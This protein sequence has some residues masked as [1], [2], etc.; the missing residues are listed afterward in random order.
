MRTG[1]LLLI[2]V[3]FFSS[4]EAADLGKV[5]RGASHHR[6]P[7]A[8]QLLDEKTAVIANRRSGTLT[9]VDVPGLSV[10]AEFDFQGEPTD[11][12]AHG[13]QLLVTDAQNGRLAALQID[14]RSA[15][16]LWELQMPTHPV[17]V[18]VSQD[19]SWCSV[20]SLWA[21]KVVFVGLAGKSAQARP[22]IIAT[23]DLPFAPREQL[24]LEQPSRLIVADAFG[25]RLA[26]IRLDAHRVEALH[27]LPGH[28]IRGLALSP[29]GD[30]I[31]IAHQ[32]LSENSPPRRSEIVWGVL[33]RDAVRT[34]QREKLLDPRADIM[35]GSRFIMI[36]NTTRGGGDPDALFVGKDGRIVI[37]LAGT[38]EVAIVEPDGFDHQRISVGRRPVAI[39]PVGDAG[40]L[41]VNELSDSL[42][43]ITLQA[44]PKQETNGNTPVPKRPRD[45]E[46]GDREA[47]PESSRYPVE[48]DEA[49]VAARHLTL[50]NSPPSGSVERGEALFF[51]ARLSAGNWY[52]CHS[53]HTDGHSSGELA[54]T[55]GDGQEG[56]PKRVLSLL[57]VAETGP[58]AWAG[59]K[60]RLHEQVDQSARSTMHGRELTTR[61]VS[62]LVAYLQTLEPPPAF[63]PAAS[64]AD[65]SVIAQ[66][67]R[68]FESLS[69]NSCHAGRTL[70][71]T[72]TYDVGLS[73][74]HGSKKF[75]P[76]SLRG[77]GHRY[78]LFHDNRAADL[79]QVVRRYKHQLPRSLSKQEE[80]MLIRYLKSL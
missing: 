75:N 43:Q 16:V 77:V 17:S 35:E 67:R 29:E 74:Q 68:L 78:R 71:S 13:G 76:P 61:E 48:G 54:D 59:N 25:G 53:C 19:G 23:V 47:Y 31:F 33:Q 18:R 41:V 11:L 57:G 64:D 32:M 69:C 6:R 30:R 8:L 58:W 9:V 1:L 2:T 12:I 44:K 21:R 22:Q 62:D 4:A 73:D 34:I 40:F 66:G 45:R 50:G 36:G 10:V 79:E 60:P 63:Q 15:R 37:A 80:Q 20:C 28:N 14:R 39:S 56:A 46:R 72:E 49:R 51:D 5:P 70:T 3:L 27:T 65:R 55:L 38:S 7:A 24:I 26:V 52:S 42:T